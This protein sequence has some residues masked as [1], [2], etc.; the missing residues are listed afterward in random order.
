M[1]KKY[2]TEL[3]ETHKGWPGY[4]DKGNVY[5]QLFMGADVDAKKQDM[6]RYYQTLILSVVI[7]GNG[8]D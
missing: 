2:R 8:A 5:I 3:I 4:E 7:L 6:W 1:I